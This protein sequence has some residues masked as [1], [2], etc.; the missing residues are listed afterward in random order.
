MAGTK[1][2]REPK[3]RQ[4]T[5]IATYVGATAAVSIARRQAQPEASKAKLYYLLIGRPGQ[6]RAALGFHISKSSIARGC[7]AQAWESKLVS[8][9][10]AW[11]TFNVPQMRM[12][13]HSR[14]YGG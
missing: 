12:C 13:V 14:C 10:G 6:S 2:Q 7:R 9:V 11:M 4:P 8:R 3:R 1:H 5:A